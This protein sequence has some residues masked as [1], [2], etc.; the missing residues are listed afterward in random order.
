MKPITQET[1]RK[2]L[3]QSDAKYI[4]QEHPV[5]FYDLFS[6]VLELETYTCA[7]CLIVKNDLNWFVHALSDKSDIVI[8]KNNI[9]MLKSEKDSIFAFSYGAPPQDLNDKIGSHKFARQGFSYK[10]PDIRKIT[11]ED[12][13]KVEI[14]CAIDKDDSETGQNMASDFLRSFSDFCIAEDIYTLGLFKSDK[15]IGFVQGETHKELGITVVNIY[16]NRAYRRKGYAKR[17]LSAICSMQQETVYCY[18]CVC[19]NEASAATARACGF[20]YMGSY[21]KLD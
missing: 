19:T 4:S 7:D 3:L 20:H 16:V 6:G 5:I 11:S 2:L 12:K 18:S 1:A 10:D 8:A 14:C 17:L 9:Q 13:E 21:L 15:L